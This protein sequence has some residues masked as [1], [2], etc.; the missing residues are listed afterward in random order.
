MVNPL[1]EKS[2]FGAWS[3]AIYENKFQV[4]ELNVKKKKREKIYL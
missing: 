3:D 2:L 1:K 4:S